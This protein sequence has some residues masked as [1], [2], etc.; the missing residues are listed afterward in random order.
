MVIPFHRAVTKL[1]S[2][3]RGAG[4]AP[5]RHT[6][7]GQTAFHQHLKSRLSAFGQLSVVSGLMAASSSLELGLRLGTCGCID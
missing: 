2:N 1:C 3:S 7:V 4:R 6:L 5:K